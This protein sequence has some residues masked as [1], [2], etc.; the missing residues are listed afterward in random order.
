MMSKR[1]KMLV[2]IAGLLLVF[3]V[4]S[5]VGLSRRGYAE[6]DEY[7]IKGFYYFF[8]EDSDA[9][10][11]KNY[12]CVI[13]Y[14]PA[15]FVDRCIGLGRYHAA[16]PLFGLGDGKKRLLGAFSLKAGHPRVAVS[17]RTREDAANRH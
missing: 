12:G 17:E 15:N 3:Y 1:M 6:A 9:W 11:R 8:P 4:G 5:Y 16:V 7:K 2:G 14:W 13:L 10:R